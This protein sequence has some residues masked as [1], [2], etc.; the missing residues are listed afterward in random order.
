M[1]FKRGVPTV[2]VHRDMTEFPEV[3]TPP[4]DAIFDQAQPYC[5]H[6][7]K[8]LISV[9]DGR[10]VPISGP[11]H[12]EDED[13]YEPWQVHGQLQTLSA[14]SKWPESVPNWTS[15]P[16]IQVFSN[17]SP[18][19]NIPGPS[20]YKFESWPA[21]LAPHGG[22]SA[23][24]LLW[25]CA[26]L[27]PNRLPVYSDAFLLSTL[28]LSGKQVF[29]LP[30]LDSVADMLSW[31]GWNADMLCGLDLC[32]TEGMMAIP[33]PGDEH[34][35]L[36][37]EQTAWFDYIIR[38]PFDTTHHLGLGLTDDQLWSH[39]FTVLCF[40]RWRAAWPDLY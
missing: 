3:A 9:Y 11:T 23:W 6:L 26:Q 10:L 37:V 28:R 17:M 40:L 34:L 31:A 39:P 36:L 19:A 22:L 33:D 13:D 38:L 7:G 5:D 4:I 12:L 15:H 24:D 35:P 21:A 29:E 14:H 20:P 27:R 32:Q 8:P 16:H 1:E 25:R 30:M 2:S 18:Y